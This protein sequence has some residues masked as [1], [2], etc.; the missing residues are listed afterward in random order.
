MGDSEAD[1]QGPGCTGYER[2]VSSEYEHD[3]KPG[4]SR[5]ASYPDSAIP[6]AAHPLCC[7][8]WTGR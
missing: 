3:I 7:S 8:I 1:C 4:V 2:L 5:G 6:Q